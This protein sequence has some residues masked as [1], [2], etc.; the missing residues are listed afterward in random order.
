[1]LNLDRKLS[2][3]PVHFFEHVL[4]EK[5]YIT[6]LDQHFKLSGLMQYSLWVLIDMATAV[7]TTNLH[8]SLQSLAKDIRKIAQVKKK[9]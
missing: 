3:L 9:L 7:V 6:L 1:M 8:I 5:R 4:H 2:V